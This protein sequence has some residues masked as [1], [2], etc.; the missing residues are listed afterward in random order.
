V[1]ESCRVDSPTEAHKNGQDAHQHPNKQF[2][3]GVIPIRSRGAAA[4]A[5]T[6]L[7][8]IR[9]WKKRREAV[10]TKIW[11]DQRTNRKKPFST[12]KE[13]ERAVLTSEVGVASG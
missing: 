5:G 1:K 7:E 11:N 4:K 3:L 9:G 2:G 13:K 10:N 12:S 8:R 6:E